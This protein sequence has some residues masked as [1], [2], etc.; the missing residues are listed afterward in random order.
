MNR[1]GYV[2]FIRCGDYVKIGFSHEPEAR[3]R[4]L[5]TGNPEKCVLVAMHEGTQS[6]ERKLHRYFVSWHVRG[7]W[8]RWCAD[9]ARVAREGLPRLIRGERTKLRL[10]NL[11]RIRR[12]P[13]ERRHGFGEDS[14]VVAFP[15]QQTKAQPR[16][17][18][19]DSLCRALR[20]HLADAE[21]AQKYHGKGVAMATGDIG[22]ALNVVNPHERLALFLKEQDLPQIGRLAHAA[23]ISVRQAANAIK[24]RPVSTIPYMRLAVVAGFDPM[25]EL[26]HADT[27]PCDFDFQFMALA[28]RMR[29]ELNGHGE[30]DAAQISGLS[31]ASVWR[32]ENAHMVSVRI[33]ILGCRYLGV[34]C[35]GYLNPV[36][37]PDTSETSTETPMAASG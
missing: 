36:S 32:I 31:L 35:F 1:I 2:Y 33:V 6:D 29:R 25:P 10:R 28:M 3:Q 9:I 18:M 21:E 22:V 4:E 13:F 11:R 34:H 5:E 8:F 37:V 14:N 20:L 7:E 16:A 23:G 17:P 30:R 27:R 19:E 15:S 24:G 26:P 12:G